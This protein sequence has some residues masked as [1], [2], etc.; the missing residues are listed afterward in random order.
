MLDRDYGIAAAVSDNVHDS[1]DWYRSY[2]NSRNT[3]SDLLTRYPKARL[4]I[5]L[6]RDSGPAK[7]ATTLSID[8]EATAKL[9]LVVGSDATM[10]HPNWRRNWETA[11]AVGAAIDSVDDG[12]LRAVRVQKG[13]YN[14]HL[15]K[16]AILLEVG[17][18][19]NTLDE[20]YRGVEVFAEAVF[21]YLK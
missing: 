4:L 6:H 3:A 21:A 14:Q 8:G 5:D 17:T 7:T 12:I 10:N 15:T 9:L 2:A 1:P 20:A 11:K 13:R 16:N 19:L 18:E